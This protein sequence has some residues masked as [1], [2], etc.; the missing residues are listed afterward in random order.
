[1]AF[2]CRASVNG[3][4]S[5]TGPVFDRFALASVIGG[6]GF[7]QDAQQPTIK[8]YATAM[9]MGGSRIGVHRFAI[10]RVQQ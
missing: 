4:W 10:Q 3:R 1:L 2:R 8:I 5:A 9:H 6:V 7:F